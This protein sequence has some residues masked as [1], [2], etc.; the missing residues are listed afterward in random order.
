MQKYRDIIKVIVEN[1][2]A[3]S[4]CNSK[5]EFASEMDMPH[6]SFHNLISGQVFPSVETVIKFR[7]AGYDLIGDYVDACVSKGLI[8]K[9]EIDYGIDGKLAEGINYKLGDWYEI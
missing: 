2:Y 6:S 4:K 3:L 7:L 8:D 5:Y 9:I 1:Y